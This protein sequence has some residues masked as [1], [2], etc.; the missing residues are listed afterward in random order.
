MPDWLAA[1][2]PLVG[3]ALGYAAASQQETK[4]WRRDWLGTMLQTRSEQYAALVEAMDSEFIVLSRTAGPDP[5]GQDRADASAAAWRSER[6]RSRVFA[7]PRVQDAAE[8]FDRAREV[9]ILAV[10]EKSSDPGAAVACLI[11]ARDDMFDAMNDDLM[12]LNRAI[13]GWFMSPWRRLLKRKALARL[14]VADLKPAPSPR[15]S[16][17]TGG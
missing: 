10:N 5:I 3:V 16:G 8:R 6:G 1:I 11:E 4:R 17:R 14:S 9:V 12:E 2:L 13:I 7:G 15:D